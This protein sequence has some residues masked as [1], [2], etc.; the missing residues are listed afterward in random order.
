M[1]PGAAFEAHIVYEAQADFTESL[2]HN[3]NIGL[4]RIRGVGR[5]LYHRFAENPELER[6]FYRYMR[7]W[8]E[9]SNPLLLAHKG[10]ADA[11]TVLD[12]GGGDAV[13]AIALARAH[14]Y[15]EITILE[16]PATAP[17]ACRRIEES[18]LAD[19]ITVHEG[20]MFQDPFPAAD[21]VLFAHQMVIWEPHENLA[22]PHPGG[23]RPA[24]LR[25]TV[26]SQD[27][28]RPRPG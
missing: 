26:T 17:L 22:L 7:A 4:R 24:P 5:D 9:L 14:P 18:G 27:R 23:R 10:F 11:R 13:N 19:R 25:L 2:R 28:P 8:S 20:D 6:V 21:R 1:R 15:L 16:I 12:V 3:T